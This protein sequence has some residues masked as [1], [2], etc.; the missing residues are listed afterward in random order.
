MLNENQSNRIARHATVSLVKAIDAF[1]EMLRDS[2]PEE[3]ATVVADILKITLT[4][5][6]P[7]PDPTAGLRAFIEAANAAGDGSP[8]NS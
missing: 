4:R 1:P 5:P 6:E 8:A 7:V 3:A 2:E